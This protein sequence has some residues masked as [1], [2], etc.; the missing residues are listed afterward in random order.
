MFLIITERNCLDDMGVND[1]SLSEDQI[2][3]TSIY[4]QRTHKYGKASLLLNSD[5]G[6]RPAVNSVQEHIKV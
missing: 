4:K 6:W 2:H 1:G 5:G 3:L